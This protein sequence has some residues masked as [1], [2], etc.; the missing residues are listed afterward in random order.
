MPNNN[1]NIN[2]Q[3][4][5]VK[6]IDYGGYSYYNDDDTD[7]T[8]DYDKYKFDDVKFNKL[9]ANRQYSD[10]ADYASNYKLADPHKQEA[11]EANIATLRSKGR[12]LNAIYSKIDDPDKLDQIEFFDNVFVDGGLEQIY[13][14][15]VN[16]NIKTNA[17]A[18]QFIDFKRN[19]GSEVDSDGSVTKEAT[20]LEVSFEPEEQSLFGFDYLYP[21]N[22]NN[23]NNFYEKLGVNKAE[24][25]DAGIQV[26]NKDGKST[27]VFDKTNKLANT[28]I[29]NLAVPHA[30]KDNPIIKYGSSYL[31]S[32]FAEPFIVEGIKENMKHI[33]VTIVGRDAQGNYCGGTDN[34]REIQQLIN[35]CKETK[36]TY[37]AKHELNEK[38]YSSTVGPALDDN[39]ELLKSRLTSGEITQTE[40]NN[41]YRKEFGYLEDIIKSMGSGAA[42]IYTNANNDESTDETLIAADNINRGEIIN[43][44]ANLDRKDI[45]FNTMV[46]N[47]T[48]GLLITT[49]APTVSNNAADAVKN[50]KVQSSKQGR[51]Q[52]FITNSEIQELVQDKINKSTL[53]RAAQEINSMQDWEYTYTTRNGI[54]IIPKADK[55]F[56]VGNEIKTREE[57]QRLINKD[58]IIDDSVRSFKYQYLNKNSKL[59]NKDQYESLAKSWA[60]AATEE[61]HPNVPLTHTDGTPFDLKTVEGR[62]AMINEIFDNKFNQDYYS[63]QINFRMWDRVKDIYEIYDEL[64]QA[65]TYYNK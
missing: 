61:L 60:V 21:D 17:Y 47:G 62:I 50:N 53:C 55:T 34:T 30:F 43:Y 31:P 3:T 28:I 48:I 11:F 8:I 5:Y 46:S 25:E 38:D 51:R 35:N 54:K 42:T 63:R 41:Q 13:N 4:K 44:F 57:A 22:E 29:Y 64:M 59:I 37:F 6:E 58:F 14:K 16:G 39:L 23:I 9:I 49:G 36:E 18:K 2:K 45:T 56:K 40:F 15:E 1:L 52:F 24:L 26:I 65:I 20:T 12:V 32:I 19:L 27:L 33:P 7:A 10:A